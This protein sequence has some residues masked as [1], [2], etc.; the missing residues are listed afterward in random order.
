MYCA[1]NGVGQVNGTQ[2]DSA[3]Q[4]RAGSRQPSSEERET[5]QRL[6]SEEIQ[7]RAEG[8]EDPALR[9]TRQTAEEE[10]HRNV[11]DESKDDLAIRLRTAGLTFREI[12]EQMGVDPSMAHRRVKRAMMRRRCEM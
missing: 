7:A 3:E 2:F 12:G 6:R 10:F 9:A 5:L 11:P 1:E 4:G 8:R